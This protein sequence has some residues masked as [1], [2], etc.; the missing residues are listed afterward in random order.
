MVVG[1][2]SYKSVARQY[3]GILNFLKLVMLR[4]PGK[5]EL[6]EREIK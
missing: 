3:R 6:I 5:E 1:V 2:S 4:V